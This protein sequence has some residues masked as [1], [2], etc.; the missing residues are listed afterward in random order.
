MF[1]F[2]V[3]DW[4]IVSTVILITTLRIRNPSLLLHVINEEGNKKIVMFEFVVCGW[5]IVCTIILIT[6]L[7]IQNP[8]LLFHVIDEEGDKK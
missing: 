8:S 2:V 5:L 6:T 4:L 3:G 1:E 7:R